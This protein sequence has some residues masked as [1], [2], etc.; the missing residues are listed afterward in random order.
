[1]D[2]LLAREYERLREPLN[3]EADRFE[4]KFRVG[5]SGLDA[6]HHMGN[7]SFLDRAHDTRMLFFAQQ[8]FTM[9]RFAAES[10]ARS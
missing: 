7:T 4:Q 9:S 1:M 10:S 3:K 6:N 5:W 8:G 2:L